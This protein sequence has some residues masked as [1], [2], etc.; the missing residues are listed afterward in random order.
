MVYGSGE[1]GEGE[2]AYLPPLPDLPTSPPDARQPAKDI[3][4][5]PWAT[6]PL[7]YGEEE[8]PTEL[9]SSYDAMHE[10]SPISAAPPVCK[11]KVG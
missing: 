7:P 6:A 9:P 5:D 1:E 3:V 8:T 11:E 10:L 2:E 4:E